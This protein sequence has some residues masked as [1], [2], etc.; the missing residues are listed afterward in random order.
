MFK[1]VLLSVLLSGL[2]SVT[3]AATADAETEIQAALDYLTQV[4]NENDMDAIA[5]YYHSD[6]RLIT[7]TGI[8]ERTQL[9]DDMAQIGKRGGDRGKVRYSGVKVE[10]LGEKHALAY[11]KMKLSFK[12]G[13][14]IENWFTTV[15]VN[16]PFGWKALLT[17]S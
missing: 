12:D 11:G 7:K 16:T 3:T 5:S 13:S 17:R 2:L 6:F 8:I 14:S 9:L 4:W 15:Y 1:T 10:S